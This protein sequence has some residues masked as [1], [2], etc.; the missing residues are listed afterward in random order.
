MADLA[1]EETFNASADGGLKTFPPAIE[2]RPLVVCLGG[3][4]KTAEEAAA[5]G[6][7]DPQQR[8]VV[9]RIEN[10]ERPARQVVWL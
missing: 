8:P 7:L 10:L 4:A 2:S 9:A 1:A 5:L 6:G 3:V